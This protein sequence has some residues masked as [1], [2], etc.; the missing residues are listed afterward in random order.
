MNAEINK[1]Y[2]EVATK[3]DSHIWTP[4]KKHDVHVLQGQ[5][6]VVCMGR[7]RTGGVVTGTAETPARPHRCRFCIAFLREWVCWQWEG[8]WQ[9]QDWSGHRQK[10]VHSLLE[11][12]A[13]E[14][15]ALGGIAS[16]TRETRDDVTGQGRG[17]GSDASSSSSPS[18]FVPRF[19]GSGC[20][21][22]GR[23]G[24]RRGLVRTSTSQRGHS[25]GEG[26]GHASGG[27]ASRT[28]E[29]REDATGRDPERKANLRGILARSDRSV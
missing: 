19:F 17:R 8:W 29:T 12:K 2:P 4:T 7:V 15:D 1:Q 14:G 23:G 11:G 20:A 22:S 6:Q 27:M 28:G 9:S 13:R 26:E 25:L 21:G 18:I 10:K 3:K 16:G 24:D 5:V